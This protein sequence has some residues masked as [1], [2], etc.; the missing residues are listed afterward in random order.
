MSLDRIP[1]TTF[2][3][4]FCS[5]LSAAV[6]MASPTAKREAPLLP[7]TRAGIR[8]FHAEEIGDEGVFRFFPDRARRA[9]G[10]NRSAVQDDDPVGQRQRLFLIVRD[11]DGGNS[12]LALDALQFEAHL[13]TQPGIEIGEGFI[14]QQ[15]FRP[16]HERAGQS[17]TLLLSARE[18]PRVAPFETRQRDE[19]EGGSYPA[20]CFGSA[21]R[22]AAQP[23]GDVVLHGHERKQGVVLEHHPE[24]APPGGQ[25][26]DDVAA[27]THLPF[28][29]F[30]EACDQPE[31][32]RLAAAARSKQAGEAARRDGETDSP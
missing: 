14:E 1:R 26:I 17:D 3:P 2:S 13:G 23:E 6:R 15:H 24:V 21:E 28:V 25:R 11:E 31:R 27:D 4:G 29:G 16:D 8:F 9:V 5:H 12:G 19:V 30:D 22:T 7:W 18:L 32:R 20:L 10:A